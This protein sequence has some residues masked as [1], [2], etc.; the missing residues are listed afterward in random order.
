MRKT[1]DEGKYS[2]M[3]SNSFGKCEA[4]CQLLITRTSAAFPLSL[5]SAH[6]SAY[7]L[8]CI[9]HTHTA[10]APIEVPKINID[11]PVKKVKEVEVEMPN[12]EKKP[13]FAFPL[14]DR[15][16]QER[17]T[18]RLTASLDVDIYPAPT[19]RLRTIV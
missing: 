6:S 7:T 9:P 8:L 13:R 16:I 4:T 1:E 17:D 11:V 5:T 3:A 18:F 12:F 10:E 15:Y 2:V 14:R 19:V